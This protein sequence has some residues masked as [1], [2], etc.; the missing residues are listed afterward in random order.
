MISN[1][2]GK[3]KFQ[4]TAG[5]TGNAF[6]LFFFF[7]PA[8]IILK[9]IKRQIE[10]VTI[11]YLLLMAN[12]M[13]CLLWFIY[14]YRKNDIQVSFCNSIGAVINV[15]YLAIFWYYFIGKN[16]PKYLCLDLLTFGLLSGIFYFFMFSV[17]DFEITGYT[18]M[19]FNIFMYAAPG[20]KLVHIILIY[21]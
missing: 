10:V 17:E 9:L 7:S 6:A 12:I 15:I 11:P 5:W 14:G 8:V 13:N 1:D 2:D 20:Q 3:D 19:V 18:A 21:R 16:I 4:I